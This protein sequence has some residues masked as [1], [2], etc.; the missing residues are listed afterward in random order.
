[1]KKLSRL[2]AVVL[3]I[4][5]VALYFDQRDRKRQEKIDEQVTNLSFVSE[6][7]SA[8]KRYCEDAA[9]YEGYEDLC[10]SMYHV[11]EKCKE[12][13]DI[14]DDAYRYFSPKEDDYDG[15]RSWFY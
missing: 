2:L 9:K 14:I 8:L 5:L 10:I 3:A 13:Q 1:M 7:L 6:E 15:R 4:V 12:L 11:E